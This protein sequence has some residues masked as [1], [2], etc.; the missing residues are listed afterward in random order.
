MLWNSEACV[1]QH[2]SEEQGQEE[3]VMERTT[4]LSPCPLAAHLHGSFGS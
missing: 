3:V 2:C 1:A 4:C